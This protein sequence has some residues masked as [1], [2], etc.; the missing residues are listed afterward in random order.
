LRLTIGGTIP[1]MLPPK[2]AAS[3][4]IEELVKIGGGY[5][6]FAANPL[7]WKTFT[8]GEKEL[9]FTLAP[10]ESTTIRYRILIASRRLE[11]ESTEKLYENWL[12]DIGR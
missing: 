5:G 1:S 8:N 10:G 6:L 9:N 11:A 4:I 7:G 3:F 12:K 2:R